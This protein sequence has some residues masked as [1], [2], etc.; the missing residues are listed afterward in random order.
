[1]NEVNFPSWD[2]EQDKVI[3]EIYMVKQ[4]IQAVTKKIQTKDI[5]CREFHIFFNNVCTTL[6]YWTG[7]TYIG[8]EKSDFIKKAFQEFFETLY[9]FLL[10]CQTH[11]YIELRELANKVLYRGALHRYLGHG[12]IDEDI[13]K[14]IEPQYNDI[15]VSWS[16]NNHNSYIESKLYGAT[17]LLTCRV[18]EPYFGIDLEV[19]EANRGNEEEVVFP[20]IKETII[21]I[22]YSEEYENE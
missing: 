10:I 13:S 4:Q 6:N 22:K 3:T 7:H 21:D 8:Q 12:F 1:M 5:D 19:F 14:H 15:Y 2:D 18:D 9:D 11:D 17:T 16:K 20:T